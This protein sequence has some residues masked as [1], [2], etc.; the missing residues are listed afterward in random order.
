MN[1]ASL[2]KSKRLQRTLAAL[3]RSS[4]VSTAKIQALTGSMAVGT[5]IS[6][7]RHNGKD[8]I[9]RYGGRTIAGAKIYLYRLIGGK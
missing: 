7:L 9:C 8:I 3:G 5:D 1:F 2:K 6:E 4:W